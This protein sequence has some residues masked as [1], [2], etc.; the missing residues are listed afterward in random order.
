M[1]KK[2]KEYYVYYHRRGEGETS[3]NQMRMKV[4][5]KNASEA[6]KKGRKELS[7]IWV[8]EKA[9]RAW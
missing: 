9:G 5:A 4:K 8:V 7:S 2:Q 6:V 3:F 1:E